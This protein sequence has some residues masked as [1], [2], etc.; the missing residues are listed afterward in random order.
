MLRMLNNADEG[1]A[2]TPTM[3]TVMM[4]RKN[5]EDVWR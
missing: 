5:K 4:L 1:C 3:A 2:M